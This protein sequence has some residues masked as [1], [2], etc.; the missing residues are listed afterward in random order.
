MKFF[1]WLAEEIRKLFPI[2]LFFFVGFGLILLIIKLVLQD[3]SVQV[4]VLSR[5]ML[6]SLV[7]GKV[8]LLLENVRLD[9][10]FPN[11]PRS[12]LI[13]LKTGF[14]TIGAIFAGAIE[15]ILE[16][17]SSSA[18]LADATREAWLHSSG[19]RFAATVLCMSL[20]FAIYFTFQE[21]DHALGNGEIF[22][23]LFK[24]PR[25]APTI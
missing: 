3:Y 22:A 11:W 9:E 4:G 24:R 5:A 12:S 19:S 10:R 14:Y 6:F 15:K 23:L 7:A 2:T 13:A 8:V 18:G 20:L 16:H 1:K 17:Y 21:V 25:T